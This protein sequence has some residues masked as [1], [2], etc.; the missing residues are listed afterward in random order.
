[1]MMKVGSIPLGNKGA[2]EGQSL[3]L[4]VQGGLSAV[5]AECDVGRIYSF[6]QDQIVSLDEP[7]R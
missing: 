4:P 6:D 2:L 1:M 7:S 5:N 3:L